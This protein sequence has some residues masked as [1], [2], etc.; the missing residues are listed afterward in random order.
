MG[1]AFSGKTGSRFPSADEVNIDCQLEHL[2]PLRRQTCG[3]I[4]ERVSRLH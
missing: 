4:C 2:E 1:L 3:R